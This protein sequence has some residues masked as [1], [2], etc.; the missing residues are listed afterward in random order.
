MYAI[1]LEL[2]AYVL[3]PD[4]ST[5]LAL[6][7]ELLLQVAAIVESSGS[8]FARPEIDHRLSAAEATGVRF[9]GPNRGT[10]N[11]SV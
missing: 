7:E 2:F 6:R 4:F 10:A 3:T 8:G 5:F 9:G 1:E 11:R